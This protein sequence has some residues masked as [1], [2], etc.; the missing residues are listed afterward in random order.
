[1][2]SQVVGAVNTRNLELN[3]RKYLFLER[4][5]DGVLHNDVS[6]EEVL[7]RLHHIFSPAIVQV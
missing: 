5:L 4:V 2:E 7:D 6:I 1:M 3:I